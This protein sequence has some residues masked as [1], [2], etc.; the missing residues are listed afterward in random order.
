MR[1]HKKALSLCLD[2]NYLLLQ[3]PYVV[4]SMEYGQCYFWVLPLPRQSSVLL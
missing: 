3:E 2:M 4:L 1:A